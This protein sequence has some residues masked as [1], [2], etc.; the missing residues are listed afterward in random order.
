MLSDQAM[1]ALQ[2]EVERL[3]RPLRAS[4]RR[5]ERMREELWGHLAG[6]AEQFFGDQRDEAWA[7]RQAV[8]LFGDPRA[9]RADLQASVP[10]YERIMYAR[11]REPRWLEA[12]GRRLWG[13]DDLGRPLRRLEAVAWCAGLSACLC[14][15]MIPLGHIALGRQ[16]DWGRVWTLGGLACGLATI[17]H[18]A[19]VPFIGGFYRYW[20]KRP[21]AEPVGRLA[22]RGA[23]LGGFMLAAGP[24][25][26]WMARTYVE[27]D[28]RDL[29]AWCVVALL[30][31]P[32]W[33]WITR[34]AADER[35]RWEEWGVAAD[36]ELLVDE[37]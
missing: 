33:A 28:G 17:V 29:A 25:F 14:L 24:A 15:L 36:E 20:L 32:L 19:E 27:F 5:K 35:Q 8:A 13:M 7:V 16:P 10:L 30:T 31:P 6:R 18:A 4:W 23:L 11:T 1:R 34:K 22:W 26:G 12:F 9:V 37:E 2:D 3:V 21:G